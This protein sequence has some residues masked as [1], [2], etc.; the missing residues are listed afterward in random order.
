M[1]M[2][3]PAPFLSLLP[4]ELDKPESDD[5]DGSGSG[6]APPSFTLH[7]G[8]RGSHRDAGLKGGDAASRVTDD[9]AAQM[10]DGVVNGSGMGD[11]VSSERQTGSHPKLY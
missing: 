3:L 1:G 2:L 7:A 11:V 10:A 5:D 4:S 9:E 8:A 6:P